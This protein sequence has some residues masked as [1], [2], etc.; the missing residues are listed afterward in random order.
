MGGGGGGV[1]TE[2]GGYL[3]MPSICAP[4]S[5]RTSSDSAVCIQ[6]SCRSGKRCRCIAITSSSVLMNIDG[7]KMDFCSERAEGG[8]GEEMLGTA[9]TRTTRLTS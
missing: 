8:G 7:W 3:K 5:W 2:G 6:G 9:S 4:P 1:M